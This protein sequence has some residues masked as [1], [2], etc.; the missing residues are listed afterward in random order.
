MNDG[1]NDKA[2]FIDVIAASILAGTFVRVTLGKF[3][4]QGEAQ[5]VVATL[6]TLKGSHNLR[7]VTSHARRDETQN[8]PVNDGIAQIA[9]LAGEAFRSKFGIPT[10]RGASPR[11]PELPRSACKRR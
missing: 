9:V 11:T 10:F 8:Y 2:I 6:V 4:G 1:T 7:I 5:K 3:R